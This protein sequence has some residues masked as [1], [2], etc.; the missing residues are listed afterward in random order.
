MHS[1]E[2]EDDH[3]SQIQLGWLDSAA[4]NHRIAIAQ[5][6]DYLDEEDAQRCRDY[7]ERGYCVVRGLVPAAVT[8]AAETAPAQVLAGKLHLPRESLLPLLEDCWRSHAGVRALMV[9]GPLLAWI[10]RLL[11][12]R[13]QPLHSLSLPESSQQGA[14]SDE[15]FMSTRPRGAMAAAWIA[16]EDV[17]AD[18][19]PLQLWPGSHRWSYLSM[20]EIG[21]RDGMSQA[22]R[23][24][25]FNERY[26]ERMA[27]KV[28]A[29]GIAAVPIILQRGDVLFWHQGLVHG[30]QRVERAGATRNSAI[31]HYVAMSA[32]SHSDA[33]AQEYPVPGLR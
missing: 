15:I 8:A 10:D 29:S 3:A 13:A 26:Y 5:A 19:G 11:G 17:H 4:A 18:A 25:L 24:R 7:S 28:V 32:E 23:E 1:K 33:W 30:A 16:L 14:H 21:G 22:E 20:A 2:E 27:A 9:Y 12:E 6:A 31:V